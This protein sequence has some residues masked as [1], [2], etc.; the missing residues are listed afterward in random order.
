MVVNS[1]L[2]GTGGGE[3]GSFSDIEVVATGDWAIASMSRERIGSRLDWRG[4]KWFGD[5]SMG[6]EMSFLGDMISS[7]VGPADPSAN[8]S[9]I[10]WISDVDSASLSL[11]PPTSWAS[12]SP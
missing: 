5:P 4:W 2:G 7:F 1:G 3:C 11:P 6:L 9:I 12:S 10:L 8:W